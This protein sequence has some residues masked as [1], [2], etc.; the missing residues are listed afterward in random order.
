MMGLLSICNNPEL[1]SIIRVLKLFMAA[2][3]IAAPIMLIVALMLEF[4]KTVKEGDAGALKKAFSNSI[5]RMIACVVLFLVPSFVNIVISVSTL[6]ESSYKSCLDN[7]TVEKIQIAYDNRARSY[8]EN[9]KKSLDR[10]SYQEA[11]KA[12]NNMSEG[13]ERT[14]LS[15]VLDEVEVALE[16]KELV[17]KVRNTKKDS[18]YSKAVEA[19]EKVKDEEIKKQLEKELE[20]I[21]L[22]MN[23]YVADYSSGGNY[24]ENTLGLPHYQQCDSRWGNIKYDIGGGPNG[25]MA[26]LCSSSCGYTSFSMI[27]AG[28][29]KDFS[30]TPPTVVSKMRNINIANGEYT[31]RGYGAASV[32]ELTSSSNMSY[33]GLNAK[34]IGGSG[35]TKR[36]NIMKELN[37]GRAVLILVPGHYMTLAPSSDT[38]KVVLLDPFSNWADSRRGSKTTT[39]EEVWNVYGGIT[40]AISYGKN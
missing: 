40:S 28:L 29:N 10:F 7:A 11:R 24:I 30:I 22:T 19:V 8:V 15:K 38:G 20:E 26:T 31:K 17:E 4:T 2:L 21:S 25:G 3:Q 12:L 6:D 13:E 5:S 37:S 36:Q 9:A 39:I 16:A 32:S 27:A 14:N 35:E 23:K 34:T 1:L 33:Y 18:D